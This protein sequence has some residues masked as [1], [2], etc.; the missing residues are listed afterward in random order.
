M[1][2]VQLNLEKK[3]DF[4]EVFNATFAF[5]R[6][7]FKM[8]FTVLGK[9]AVIPIVLISVVIALNQGV[10]YNM[11]LQY[12]DGGYYGPA[13][14]ATYGSG[15]VG[16]LLVV[17]LGFLLYIY[18]AGI[19]FSYIYIYSE[20]GHKG[21]TSSEV[22]QRV[23]DIFIKLIGLYLFIALMVVIAVAI[24]AG[25]TAL[26]GV[27]TS[28]SIGPLI[29]S[30]FLFLIIPIIYL[31]VPFSISYVAIVN[32]DCGIWDSIVRSF[33]L[34]KGYWWITFFIMLLLGVIMY[35]ISFLFTVP[36]MIYTLIQGFNALSGGAGLHNVTFGF[37]ITAIISSVGSYIVYTI[38]LTGIGVQYF[39]L[40][41]RKD[42]V[43]LLQEIS[44]IES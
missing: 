24:G 20:K 4:S 37:V 28:P 23:T 36:A 27:V 32:E 26:V 2:N 35:M 12:I 19:T 44:E 14:A 43:R 33:R 38:Y 1:S 41:E 8:F 15:I 39:N 17:F 13:P 30:A 9:Y 3:R 7:E 34:I 21:F 5:F 18:L 31:S 25:V 29:V 42:N 10:D 16:T 11:L 40:R 22:W 6:Q